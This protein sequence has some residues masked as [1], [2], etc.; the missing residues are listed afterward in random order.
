GR[1][2]GRR[3]RQSETAAVAVVA[4]GRGGWAAG[5][6]T[7]V[8]AA[9]PASGLAWRAALHLRGPA[10]Q[11]RPVRVVAD[12]GRGRAAPAVAALDAADAAPRL[13]RRAALQ[14]GRRAGGRGRR[15]G[16]RRRW[17]GGRRRRWRGGRAAAGGRAR[18]VPADDVERDA[19][20]RLR[21]DIGEL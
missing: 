6:V 12:W 4:H 18:H 2:L 8:R 3:R 16:R 13:A 20:R 10:A 7:A 9:E 15:R 21:R 17:R 1:A 19:L 14:F 11:A 5:A